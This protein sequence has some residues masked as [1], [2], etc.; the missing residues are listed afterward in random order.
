VSSKLHKRTYNLI[1]ASM[2]A[3][4]SMPEGRAHGGSNPAASS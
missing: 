2:R 3:V 4:S 1:E